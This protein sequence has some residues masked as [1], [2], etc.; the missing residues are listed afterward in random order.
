MS[1]ISKYSKSKINIISIQYGEEKITINVAREAKIDSNNIEDEI[2]RQPSNYGFLFMLHKRLLTEFE[3]LKLRRKSIF[4]ELLAAAKRR[5]NSSGRPLSDNDAKAWVESNKKYI[6][7]SERCINKRDE[8]D[9][10]LGAV[11]ALEQKKD[12]LQSLSANL[13]TERI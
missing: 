10:V 7:I 9:Q 8:A 11:R 2:K 6:R 4:G 3:H 13:R 1:R 5:T 12:L